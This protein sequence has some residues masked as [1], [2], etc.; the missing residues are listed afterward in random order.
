MNLK[1]TLASILGLIA[2]L[3]GIFFAG[4][5]AGKDSVRAKQA[6]AAIKD[7]RKAHEIDNDTNRLSDN[8]LAERLRQYQ[9]RD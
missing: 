6:E 2:G 8:E 4:R 3:L 1:A 5:K 7:V 9:R